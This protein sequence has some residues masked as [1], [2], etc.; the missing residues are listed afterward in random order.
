ML[1]SYA[2]RNEATVIVTS[3]Y[4]QEMTAMTDAIALLRDGRL[5]MT[6]AREGALESLFEEDLE[7]LLH[8][9]DEIFDERTAVS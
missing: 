1:E 3:H 9:V 5:E 2:A 4:I 7:E 8:G 6:E